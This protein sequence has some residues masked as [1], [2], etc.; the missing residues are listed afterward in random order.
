MALRSITDGGLETELIFREGRD[1][2][3]FAAFPLVDEDEGRDLLARYFAP[4]IALA[5]EAGIGLSLGA[6]TWRA[7][8]DWGARLGYGAADLARVNA[9]AV[10]FMRQLVGQSPVTDAQVG[11]SVGP[12]GDGYRTGTPMSADEARRYHAPQV[13]AL[14]GAGAH[15]VRAASITQVG[16]AAGI[17]RAARD[18]GLPVVVSFTL[19][20]DGRLPDGAALGDVIVAV[21]EATAGAAEYFMVNCVHP[22][23]LAPALAPPAPWHARIGGIRANASR[24]SH[25]ELDA[26]GALESG[27]PDDFAASH[28]PLRAALPA[29]Q[30]LGGCCGTNVRHV[31]ALATAWGAA[32]A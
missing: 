21:D 16:E 14:A 32:D 1:L 19:E 17:V 26:A 22:E 9:Q 31:A 2:P 18:A 4:Y 12:R 11:G 15:F 30:V 13:E 25:A 6:P 7:N 5:H 29:V 10:A 3:F 20:T 27:D 28:L 24:L 8:R 23:H